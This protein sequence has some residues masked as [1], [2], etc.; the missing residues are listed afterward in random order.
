[1]VDNYSN[2][3][4]E[5]CAYDIERVSNFDLINQRTLDEILIMI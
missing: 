2:K 1:M 3:K 5:F 4:T